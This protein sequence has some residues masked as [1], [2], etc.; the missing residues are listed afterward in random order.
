MIKQLL[1][2]YHRKT[3]TF[4]KAE[5]SPDF[6]SVSLRCQLEHFT[7]FVYQMY[8][9]KTVKVMGGAAAVGLV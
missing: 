9:N 6:L 3:Q 2:R 7:H 4:K 8:E 1:G 5:V